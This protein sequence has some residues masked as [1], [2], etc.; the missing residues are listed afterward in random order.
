MRSRVLVLL[1]VAA[2]QPACVVFHLDG[3]APGDINVAAP[4]ADLSAEQ[5]EQPADPGES[6]TRLTVGPYGYMGGAFPRGRSAAFA[7]EGGLELSITGWDREVSHRAEDHFSLFLPDLDLVSFNASWAF[8][9]SVDDVTTLG[10][11][12]A[13]LQWISGGDSPLTSLGG[14]LGAGVDITER[15]FS[16]QAT[17]LAFGGS[18]GLRVRY[19]PA[20]EGWSVGWYVTYKLPLVWVYSR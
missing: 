4:P 2:L 14:A 11:L 18:N 1:L 19:T 15:A 13:E 16:L 17:L 5:A 7:A 20:A 12:F 10:P 3:R 6:V 9:Q 8:V